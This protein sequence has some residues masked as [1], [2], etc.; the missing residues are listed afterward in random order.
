VPVEPEEEQHP[1]ALQA[2][3]Q[4]PDDIEDGPPHEDADLDGDGIPD[5]LE[6]EDDDDLSDVDLGAEDDAVVDDDDEEG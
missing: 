1:E 2:A 6:V 5:H 3:D 4:H